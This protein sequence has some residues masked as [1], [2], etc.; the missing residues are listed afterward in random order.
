MKAYLSRLSITRQF[1]LVAALGVIMTITGLALTLKR[2]HDLAYEAKRS[3]IQHEGEEGA[4]IVRHFVDLEKSGALSRQE[5][6]KRAL[7]AVG[8]IR[9]DSV[10]YVAILNFDG[11]SLWNANTKLI[12]HNIMDLKDA[13]GIP[14]TAAQIA[15]GKSGTPGFTTFHW[16]KIGETKPKL[17]MSYNIGIPEWEWDVTTGSFADDLN[18]TLLD[19]V[20]RL[21]EIFVPIFLGYLVIVVLMHRTV[22][23]VLGSMSAA[24]RRLAAG[25]LDTEILGRDRDDELG[26]MA[27]ALVTFRQ[28]AI[29]KQRLEAQAQRQRDEADRQRLQM[30]AVRAE[31]ERQR[32]LN[33]ESRTHTAKEQAQVV[34]SIG[35]GLEKLA[36]G[37]LTF[38]L[39]EPFT[40]DYEKLRTDFNDAMVQVLEVMKSVVIRAHGL[41][42]GGIEIN[43]ASDDLSRRTEQQ[44]ASL[45][46]TASALH[47]I[48]AT[49]G[50]TAEG[51][52]HARGIVSSAASGAEQSAKIVREAVSTMNQIED[53]SRQIS[54]IVGVI[55]EIAFQTNLLALNAAVE[56][57][58]AGEQG[59]GFAVVAS[60]VRGL[61]QRS[62]SAAKEIKALISASTEQVARGVER[63]AATGQ[64]LARIAVEVTEINTV[65]AEIADAAQEQAKGLAE[66]NSAVTQMDQVTQQN[67]AM[68]E[69]M[70]A[71]ARSLGDETDA[72]S[73]LIARFRVDGGSPTSSGR[74]T[75]ERMALA[76]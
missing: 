72:L 65:V 27:E 34:K 48:T 7:E 2:S 59:R 69:Q 64:S 49:V 18:S 66:V 67:A 8:A 76:G 35:L 41:R 21:A 12:G 22:A 51:A 63:V 29:D 17:K 32:H 6:Q 62:A 30:E 54:Q 74:H 52:V 75:A 50:K 33:E 57:A 9:F 15:I 14:V 1:M 19:S 60:E 71:A 37:D 23:Q 24:M 47:E 70:T 42:T 73:E 39:K 46:E 25:A 68:V 43:Q 58:R 44:A 20:L 4:A 11:T 36:S 26:Q 16:L 3:E 38:R 53:S 61:A 56:A 10:N 13:F 28:A 5:S 55:D 45:E 31:A 40:A